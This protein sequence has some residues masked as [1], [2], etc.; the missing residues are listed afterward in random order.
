MEEKG[1]APLYHKM[2]VS[3]SG[4]NFAEYGLLLG[5]I[6]VLVVVAAVTIGA[7]LLTYL[8]TLAQAIESWM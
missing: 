5:F 6:A 2:H 4:Q 1:V 8:D 3:S 7:D